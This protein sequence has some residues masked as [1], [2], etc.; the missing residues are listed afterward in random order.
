MGCGE[1]MNPDLQGL[2]VYYPLI[3]SHNKQNRTC[4]NTI[5]Y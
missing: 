2:V 3:A 5:F 4:P 1:M